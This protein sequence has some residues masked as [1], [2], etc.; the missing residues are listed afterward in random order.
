MRRVIEVLRREPALIG[1]LV[2]TVL[3]AFVAIR[4]LDVDERTVASV[5]VIVN[6]LVDCA[7]R[8]SVTSATTTS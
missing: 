1:T 5:V 3:P 8:F 6:A 2:G 7:V 4:L